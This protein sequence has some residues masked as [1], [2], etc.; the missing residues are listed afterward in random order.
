[1]LFRS[2]E[3]PPLPN[4]AVDSRAVMNERRDAVDAFISAS[5]IYLDCLAEVSDTQELSDEQNA[6]AAEAHNRM[7]TQQDE[8]VERFNEQVGIFK[9]REE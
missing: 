5:N 3:E 4:G 9:A 8:L 1:M 6:L 7:V 2:S